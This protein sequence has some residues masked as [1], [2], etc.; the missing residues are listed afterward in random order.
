MNRHWLHV[1]RSKYLQCQINKM[2]VDLW[3]SASS[4][5]GFQ[6]LRQVKQTSDWWWCLQMLWLKS[7]HD[8]VINSQKPAERLEKWVG[9]GGR[10]GRIQTD[11]LGL[12]R[13]ARRQ[14]TGLINEHLCVVESLCPNSPLCHQRSQW[15]HQFAAIIT[16]IGQQGRIEW[17]RSWGLCECWG[18]WLQLHHLWT[19]KHS[20][21]NT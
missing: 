8:E 16:S 9:M 17:R 21:V 4:V 13:A 3:R 5:I 14:R 1:I 12:C 10:R 20:E 11:T 7:V 6:F 2:D 19:A 18:R 15:L